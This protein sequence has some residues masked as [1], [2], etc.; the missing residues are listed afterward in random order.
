ML[1]TALFAVLT[2]ALLSPA[3]AADFTE[4]KSLPGAI[5][6]VMNIDF[7]T[8]TNTNQD[9]TPAPESKDIYSTDINVVNSLAL[10]GKIVRQP[11]LPT[12]T[13]GTTKQDG[14][15][16]YDLKCVLRNPKDPN[17]TI[18][19]GSWIGA[20][21]IDGNGRYFLADAPEERGRL[22]MATDS[23]GKITGFTSNYGG[24]IQGRI[25]EQAGL[26]G[27]A[28]RASA[29]VS[30]TYTRYVNGKAVT[31]TVAGADP[32]GFKNVDLAQG[33]L[34]GYPLSH[35]NG[36]VDYDAETGIWYVDV[37]TNYM[38]DGQAKNDRYSG[39]IRWNEDAN[40]KVNGIGWYDVNVR[41][42]EK[43]TAETDAFSA[44]GTSQEDEFFSADTAVPGFTGKIA[45]IDTFNG[46]TVTASKVTYNVDGNKVSKV[47]AVNFAKL[48]LLI[49]GPFNDE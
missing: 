34:S 15:L 27:F 17:Q 48:L 21:R 41:V 30:K 13:L 42:N 24:E 14:F 19:L 18:T 20:M 28:S 11:W 9:G 16:A 23:F 1:R 45:Y 39:T 7:Q 38:A 29:K 33:P 8:R 5:V 25:P 32:M 49:V 47:Q 12:G 10:K 37:S 46:D 43:A 2:G 4:E 3:F 44:P 40:R 35:L 26:W 36:S 22:R 31:H 6:G